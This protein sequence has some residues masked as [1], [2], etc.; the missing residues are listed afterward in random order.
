V[1]GE[2]RLCYKFDVKEVWMLM[3]TGITVLI[4]AFSYRETVLSRTEKKA[5]VDVEW[6]IPAKVCTKHQNSNKI[7]MYSF[8]EG[9]FTNSGGKTVSAIELECTENGFVFT[10]RQLK[11]NQ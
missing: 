3:L 2:G 6:K 11:D 7:D 9:I 8:I 10:Q 5:Q 4:S 1:Q